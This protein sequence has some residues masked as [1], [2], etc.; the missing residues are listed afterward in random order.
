MAMNEQERRRLELDEEAIS[1]VDH[2]LKSYKYEAMDEPVDAVD[3]YQM[4]DA[5]ANYYEYTT[6]EEQ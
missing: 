1:T 4:R 2:W 5:I 6:G 3:L